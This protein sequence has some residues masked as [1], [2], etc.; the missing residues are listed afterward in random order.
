MS[1]WKKIEDCLWD[2]GF[3]VMN[4]NGSI[5]WESEKGRHSIKS[6][7]VAV[8]GNKLAW[9]Q[10]EEYGKCWIRILKVNGIV[11]NWKPYSNHADFG[12]KLHYIKWFGNKLIVIY[13]EKHGTHVVQIEDLT[14]TQLYVGTIGKIQIKENEIYILGP[15][16]EFYHRILVNAERTSLNCLPI[17]NLNNPTINVE[18]DSFDLYSM[19]LEEGYNKS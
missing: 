8:D 17:A 14:I 9:Y 13:S 5:S 1:Y 16:P 10:D 4:E 3:D 2:E 6:K 7:D 18:L 15:T 12:F 19:K 11:I